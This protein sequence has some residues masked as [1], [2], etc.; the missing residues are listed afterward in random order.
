[1]PDASKVPPPSGFSSR[2]QLQNNDGYV[3]G[4]LIQQAAF[5]VEQLTI[6]QGQVIQP[7]ESTVTDATAQSVGPNPYKGL[8]AFQETDGDRFFGRDQ[9][10]QDLWQRLRDLFEDQNAVRLLPIY[11][12][13]G[14]GKSSLA[15][16]GLIPALAKQPL[17]GYEQARVAVF[18]PGTCP[19]EAL[20]NVLAQIATDE[21]TPITKAAEFRSALA[22]PDKLGTY[23]GLRQIADIVPRITASPL[24]IVVDQF[25]EIYS[26][27][28]DE[29][30]R[31]AFIA[32]L[33]VAAQERSRRVAVILTLRSDFLGQVQSSPML[34]QLFSKQGVL[35]PM[36]DRAALRE[37]I[38]Q[39]A[40]QA[41]H[42]FDEATISLLI[43]QSEER[44][45]ALP[46]LQFALTRMWEGFVSCC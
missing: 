26:L 2:Q 30:A 23:N 1:M 41:G 46:L 14:S 16:A 42:P 18:T 10:I 31:E 3:I 35:V 36:M 9:P 20:A 5:Q 25:E 38:A 24:F 28:E 40:E 27:C 37:A 22:T 15:R 17:P 11:G 39:P 44:E 6:Y 12:P 21:M 43:E 19:L 33:V 32:N 4:N 45:G 7:P 34:N 13:S 29:S 8:A